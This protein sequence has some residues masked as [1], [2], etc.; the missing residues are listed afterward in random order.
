MSEAFQRN[1]ENEL[2]SIKSAFESN[3]DLSYEIFQ[4][5]PI[6]ICITNPKGYFTDVNT[7]YCDIYGYTR[8]ELIGKPFTV[9]VPDQSL[10]VLEQLHADFMEQEQELQGR[11]TVKNK[12]KEEFEIITNA[13][14]LQDA[15]TNENRKMT[16]VVKANELELTI[17]RLK[18]TIDILEN[19]IKTQDIAN[20]LAEHDMR[21]RIGSMVS[22]AD[23]LSKSDLNPSQN[24]W[25]RMLKDIGNDTLNLL[26]SAK[27]YAEMERGEY[28]P[29]ISTFDL[30]ELIASTTSEMRD[31]IDEKET[32]IELYLNE[33]LA[34]PEEDI[35][36]IK[37]DK[38]YMSHLF[39]N[40]LRNAIEASPIKKKVL[41]HVETSN[42]IIINIKNT[43]TIPQ[44]IRNNFFDKYTTDGKERGTGLGT[45]ISKMVAEIHHGNL[46]FLTGKDDTT[47]LILKLPA[48]I[49]V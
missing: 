47:T 6:G 22:I 30:I 15:E 31:L 37:G 44:K 12:N 35:L 26:T 13:A 43:G 23:I 48:T 49:I 32:E 46:S 38:F 45:Y 25:V 42:V 39:Q 17:Q 40:L 8:E 1:T 7:T 18:T 36:E 21:N 5:M 3:Q 41:I 24:K 14:F 11:W 27:D 20:K 16:L 34:E 19:K 28:T 9:V 29:E 33:T 2:A 4:Q 10:A